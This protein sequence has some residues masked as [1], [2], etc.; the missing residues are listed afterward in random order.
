MVIYAYD[1]D[2]YDS[3][4]TMFGETPNIKILSNIQYAADDNSKEHPIMGKYDF[5][6]II[7]QHKEVR[8]LI[9]L[10]FDHVK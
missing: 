6:A 7:E 4:K 10:T 3:Y 8:K 2:A 9:L 1:K 5:K